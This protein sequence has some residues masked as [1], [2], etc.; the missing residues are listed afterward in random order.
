ML[1]LLYLSHTEFSSF[2]ALH[3]LKQIT[4]AL[5]YYSF[6][7]WKKTLIGS[8]N[9]IHWEIEQTLSTICLNMNCKESVAY[10][11]NWYVETKD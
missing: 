10:N 1:Y 3:V 11:F 2:S 6:A 9:P 7:D 5:C 4:V 8:L